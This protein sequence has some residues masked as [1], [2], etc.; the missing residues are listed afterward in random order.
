M[1]MNSPGLAHK[2]QGRQGEEGSSVGA[3]EPLQ[4]PHISLRALPRVVIAAI[5][6]S[7]TCLTARATAPP[8]KLN[9]R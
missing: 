4:L 6:A 8:L 7:P 5:T 1:G 2:L 3:A 9:P